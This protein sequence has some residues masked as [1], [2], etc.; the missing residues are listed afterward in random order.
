MA[1]KKNTK[2]QKPGT[3]WLKL[4]LELIVVF[5]EIIKEKTCRK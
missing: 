2:A 3:S 1:K 4:M 5:P